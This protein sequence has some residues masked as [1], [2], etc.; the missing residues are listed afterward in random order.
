MLQDS[1]CSPPI[2]A[3][4]ARTTRHNNKGLCMYVCKSL[5]LLSETKAIDESL[6]ETLSSTKTEI[7]NSVLKNR[8]RNSKAVVF[9]FVEAILNLNLNKKI[10]FCFQQ[11]CRQKISYL[12][13][14]FSFINS[15]DKAKSKA[16]EIYFRQFVVSRT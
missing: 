9:H 7:N 14:K 11:V 13:L 15:R 16:L 12:L 3:D 10:A 8:K 4:G 6:C 1:S 2:S 5:H